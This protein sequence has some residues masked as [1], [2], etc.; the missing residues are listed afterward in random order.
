MKFLNLS[1]DANYR[2]ADKLYAAIDSSK[3]SKAD[4]KGSLEL[5]SYGLMDAGFT[6]KILVG[7]NRDNFVIFRLNGNNV[8]DETYISELLINIFASDFVSRTAA[9]TYESV[10]KKYNGIANTN[11]VFFVFGRTWDFS[12]RYN[13]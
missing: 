1:L 3:F 11:Q 10:R 13:F 9:P 7:K 5:L 6:Y 2:F 8:L 4:N 12:L